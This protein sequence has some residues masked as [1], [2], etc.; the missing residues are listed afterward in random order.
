LHLAGSRV[1]RAVVTVRL[2]MQLPLTMEM[3]H[4][5][6]HCKRIESFVSSAHA[7]YAVAMMFQCSSYLVGIFACVKTVKHAS[8]HALFADHQNRLVSKFTCHDHSMTPKKIRSTQNFQMQGR[9]EGRL[10]QLSL[11][12]QRCTFKVAAP[13]ILITP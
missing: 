5:H 2:M 3:M 1:K 6:K 4:M 13:T 8:M 9:K 12:K 10:H 7:G 11:H